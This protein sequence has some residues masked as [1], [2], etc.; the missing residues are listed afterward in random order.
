MEFCINEVLDL[1]NRMD[2]QQWLYTL[3]IVVVLGLVFLRGFGSRS[4][5]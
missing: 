2:S 3:A 5:Y 1:V 4:S